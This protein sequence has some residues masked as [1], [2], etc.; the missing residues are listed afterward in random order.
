VFYISKT[1]AWSGNG[2]LLKLGRVRVKTEPAFFSAGDSFRQ[3]LHLD[4]GTIS[5]ESGGRTILFWI[6]ANAPVIHVDVDSP[7]QPLKVSAALEVWRCE[8]RELKGQE[9]HSARGLT[10]HKGDNAPPIFADPDVILPAAN[11]SVRWYHRNTNTCY[12]VTLKT[13]HL[14]YLLTKY[15]DPL[16]NLTFGAELS[17]AG[18]IADGDRMLVSKAPSKKI[19]I[20]VT[21]LTKQTATP[22]AWETALA[23]LR[24]KTSRVS[25]KKSRKLHE[26]YWHNF[27]D[28]SRIIVKDRQ[29]YALPVNKHPWR[30]GVDSDGSS[31]FRGS[32]VEPR[33]I[34][35]ALSAKEIA[36][37]AG[38]PRS[39]GTELQQ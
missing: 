21:A 39:S 23:E 7:E 6:D 4:Q 35:H 11:N 29:K 36:Q 2:R 18:M 16:M 3:E 5:F 10:A 37:L 9:Q 38:M 32:I 31:R 28:R 34:G 15:R 19:N 8:R 13:Q 1:D 12:A 17:A 20:T 33:I 22:E 30:V 27:W 25:Y 14:G 24:K 26:K